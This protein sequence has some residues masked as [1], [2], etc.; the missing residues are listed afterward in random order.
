MIL[1]MQNKQKE[2]K[3]TILGVSIMIS[4]RILS[5]SIDYSCYNI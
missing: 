2:I 3:H 4:F 5:L 1:L